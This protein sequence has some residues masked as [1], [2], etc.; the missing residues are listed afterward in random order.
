MDLTSPLP[1]S[2]T[3]IYRSSGQDHPPTKLL[4]EIMLYEV[5]LMDTVMHYKLN[6][7]S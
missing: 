5:L 7:L 4:S 2:C 6:S 1:V 3:S